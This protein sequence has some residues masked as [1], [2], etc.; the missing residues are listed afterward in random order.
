MGYLISTDIGIN[1]NGYYLDLMSLDIQKTIGA[2]PAFW[3]K[4]LKGN[5]IPK[6]NI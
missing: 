3:T 6:E 5:Y 2:N 4:D 1:T